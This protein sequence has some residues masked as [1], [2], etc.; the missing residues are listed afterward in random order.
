MIAEYFEG[1]NEVSVFPGMPQE[2]IEAEYPMSVTTPKH[3][4]YGLPAHV[5]LSEFL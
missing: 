1:I 5:V 4:T 3:D 2:E